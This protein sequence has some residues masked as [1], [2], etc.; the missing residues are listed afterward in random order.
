MYKV[1][2]SRN[3]QHAIDTAVENSKNSEFVTEAV[4]ES[5]RATQEYERLM[6]T[7]ERYR[8]LVESKFL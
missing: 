7:D 8:Q 5:D 6:E 1:R 4:A 2:L 3:M